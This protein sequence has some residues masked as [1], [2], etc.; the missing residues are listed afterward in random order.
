MKKTMLLAVLMA[1]FTGLCAAQDRLIATVNGEKINASDL[2]KKMWWQHSAQALSDVVDEKLLLAEVA[3][4]NVSYDTKEA[5]L[6]FEN[7][8]AGYKDRK[9]FEKNLRSVGWTE[10]DVK[11]L[12]KKQM[13]IKA[14]VMAAKS[15]AYTD[16]DAATFFEANKAK[17]GKPETA[18]IRQIFV[19]G[20]SEADD[21]YLALSAGADFGKLSALK[22]T[23]ENLKKVEGDLGYIARGL[24]LPEL[25]KEIYALQAG[26]YTKPLVT[27]NGFSIFKLE[28]MKPGEPAVLNDKL[29]ADIKT[30]LVNQAV[31]QKLPELIGELRAKA[32][33]ELAK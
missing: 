18:K 33:I 21:A 4:L 29:K 20:K 13:L 23:D 16:A 30:A 32:K 15:I 6:R 14:A 17:L 7:I 9:E 11:D 24:L 27:G 10:K 5:D 31:T 8:A 12:I 1:V 22:S 19:A 3:R 2:T 28:D 25:E 26:Q